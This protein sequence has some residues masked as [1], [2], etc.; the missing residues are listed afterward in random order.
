MARACPSGRIARLRL[1]DN[2]RPSRF[3][4]R[5][6]SCTCFCC[7]SNNHTQDR[8][9]GVVQR[10]P[11]SGDPRQRSSNDRPVKWWSPRVRYWRRLDDDRLR[12]SRHSARSPRHSHRP[13]GRSH[14]HHQGLVRNR[15]CRFS[16]RVLQHHRSR[17]NAETIAIA[18]SVPHWR[19]WQESPH[20]RGS[21]GRHHRH[22][23]CAH[24]WRHRCISRSKRHCGSHRRKTAV[25]RRCRWQSLRQP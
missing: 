14:H 23:R 2:R 20:H 1:T 7:R 16:R 6:H 13:H 24:S 25:D 11:P 8:H 22:Q 3:P 9:V 5:D 19:R 21:R 15:T 12:A 10:L 17:R 18:G 4:V